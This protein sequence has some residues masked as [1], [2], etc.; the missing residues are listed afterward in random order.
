MSEPQYFILRHNDLALLN[1]LVVQATD[2]I[3]RALLRSSNPAHVAFWNSIKSFDV[4]MQTQILIQERGNERFDKNI[5]TANQIRANFIKCLQTGGLFIAMQDA[6][7][8][9]HAGYDVRTGAA[10]N[11]TAHAPEKDVGVVCAYDV[12]HP[13]VAVE[14]IDCILTH[15][16]QAKDIS[17][18]AHT[19]N[20]NDPMH[21]HQ[22]IPTRDMGFFQTKAANG[23]L[24]RVVG[25]NAAAIGILRPWR[26]EKDTSVPYD[27]PNVG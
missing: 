4:S 3:R 22:I 15:A 10:L 7:I 11:I 26:G 2:V 13:T 6:K 19:I 25:L 9:G 27:V 20:T 24:Y 8:I 14:L 23:T 5:A 16:R 18:I 12:P 1:Q 17:R 21:I